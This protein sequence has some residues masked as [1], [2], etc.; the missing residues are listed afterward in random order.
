[1]LEKRALHDIGRELDYVRR[2][3]E[4]VAAASGAEEAELKFACLEGST[5]GL[6]ADGS[7]TRRGIDR[8][9]PDGRGVRAERGQDGTIGSSI[10]RRGVGVGI[11]VCVSAS[12]LGKSAGT[13]AKVESDDAAAATGGTPG[14]TVRNVHVRLKEAARG[15]RQLPNPHTE[16]GRKLVEEVKALAEVG[17]TPLTENGVGYMRKEP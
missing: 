6:A 4:P 5:A 3:V 1:M 15:K 2:V 17:Q 9:K 11:G 12:S 14:N 7:N 16:L 8:A 13:N 10:R